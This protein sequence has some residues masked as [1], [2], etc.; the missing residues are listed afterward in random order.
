M[1]KSRC[2]EVLEVF[3]DL[4]LGATAKNGRQA[5]TNQ[6]QS[7]QRL[8]SDNTYHPYRS[9]AASK[10]YFRCSRL[11][12]TTFVIYED[13]K[14]EE[15]PF[16]YIKIYDDPRLVILSDT[17]CGGGSK[18]A[19]SSNVKEFIETCPVPSNDGKPLNPRD[20]DG[21][22]SRNYAIF[23][24]HCH[25]D[26][27]LG[28]S[29]F[30]ASTSTIVASSHNKDFVQKNLAEHSLC[31]FVGVALPEYKVS[32]WV[33]DY[34][35]YDYNG[36]K[37]GLQVL[38]TP[39]HTPDELAFYDSEERHLYVGDSFYER[40]AADRSYEQAILFPKEG[41]LVDYMKSL[42]KL[43]AFVKEKNVE[44]GK[45][46]VKIGCGHVT[47]AVDGLEILTAVKKLFVDVIAGKLPAVESEQKRGEEYVTWREAGESKFS[48]TAPKRLVLDASK[49][50]P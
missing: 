4:A 10:P 35:W 28:L 21:N 13:D 2:F 43:F 25:Y 30:Q 42:D 37:L 17:G 23:C 50:V 31:D 19:H 18:E 48:V 14:Y 40:V 22:P 3:Q 27:I 24:T 49:V 34:E 45:S 29:H 16:M 41:N 47:S 32:Y 39:G 26:H 12:S 7:R 5:T 38:H 6:I 36:Q 46:P 33:K 44:P 11:N 8:Q 9:M 15:H 20:S 1:V